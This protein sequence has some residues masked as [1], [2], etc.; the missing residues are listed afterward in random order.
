[1]EA[2]AEQVATA[3]AEIFDPVSVSNVSLVGRGYEAEIFGF[4]LAGEKLVLRLF[5]H[6]ADD[7]RA[8]KEFTVQARLHRLGYPVPQVHLTLSSGE[9]ELRRPLV[10]MKWVDGTSLGADFWGGTFERK[11]AA[12]DQLYR[13][14]ADLHLLRVDDVF[15]PACDVSLREE[16]AAMKRL[17]STSHGLRPVFDWLLEQASHLPEEPACVVHGDFH[18]NNVLR[19]SDSS[20]VIDWSNCRPGDYRW[21][22]AWIRL[23]VRADEQEDGGSRALATYERYSG[24]RPVRL[25]FFEVLGATKILLEA[26]SDSRAKPAADFVAYLISLIEKR[27]SISVA[28]DPIGR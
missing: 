14:M 6:A 13:L 27:T 15:G 9:S 20:V 4:E 1:M 11:Q 25:D 28:R 19:A 12:E 26:E 10:V 2:T 7:E 23:L 17:A 22:V 18:A 5:H 16:V 8:A 21:D 24:R 3:L